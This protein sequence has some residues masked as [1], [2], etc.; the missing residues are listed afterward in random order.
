MKHITSASILVAGLCLVGCAKPPTAKEFLAKEGKCLECYCR[1]NALTAETALLDCVLYAQKCQKVGV[2][3]ILYDEVFA[4]MYGRLYL[5]ERHLGHNA[6]AEQYLEKYAHFH[7]IAG[8]LARYTGRPHGEME[9]LIE[10][11]FD[12]DLQVAW[13]VG[14]RTN[15][16]DPPQ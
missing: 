2:N 7:G 8:S 16:T 12:S 13:K 9:R 6:D 10:Q 15:A 11:K 14:P 3:D 5:V 4:R 1:S